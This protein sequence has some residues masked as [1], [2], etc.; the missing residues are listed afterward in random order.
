MNC[1]RVLD[2]E[3]RAPKAAVGQMEVIGK[4]AIPR[5]R[6]MLRLRFL[7]GKVYQRFKSQTV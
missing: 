6:L 4:L 3:C 2:T 5:D 7:T 1:I